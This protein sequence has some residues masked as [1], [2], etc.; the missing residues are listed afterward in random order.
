ME[1]PPMT[2]PIIKPKAKHLKPVKIPHFSGMSVV[3]DGNVI[4]WST[5]MKMLH[6]ELEKIKNP[7]VG[8]EDAL[9]AS[10]IHWE[11]SQMPIWIKKEP[12]CKGGTKKP[13][14]P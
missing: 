6:R 12:P 3:V 13:S 2:R 5:A 1:V 11:K 10:E 7:L 14:K 4:P 8:E 9:L